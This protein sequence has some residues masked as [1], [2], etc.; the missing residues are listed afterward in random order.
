MRSP[1]PQALRGSLGPPESGAFRV[2]CQ[3]RCF[4]VQE[5]A[6]P[7]IHPLNLNTEHSKSS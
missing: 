6:Q 2:G 1:G 7:L 4:R 5:L 3:V